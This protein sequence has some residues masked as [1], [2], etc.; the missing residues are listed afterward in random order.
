MA[1]TEVTRES[2]FSRLGNSIKGM[3]GGIIL[4]VAGIGVTAWNEGRAV[5]T[6][7]GL[8]EGSAAVISVES[9][10][11][12]SA[13]E[14]RLVHLSGL[15]TTEEILRDDIFAVEAKALRLKRNA[16]ML[17]WKEKSSSKTQNKVG[18]GTETVTTYTYEKVWSDKVIPSD[19]FREAATHVNPGVLPVESATKAAKVVTLGGFQLGGSM[20]G[21]VGKAEPLA[22]PAQVP[23]EFKVQGNT[24]YRSITPNAVMPQPGAVVPNPLGSAPGAVPAPTAV[25]TTPAAMTPQIGD[26][27]ITFEV[28]KPAEVSV[29]AQQRGARLEPY[30]TKTGTSIELVDDGVVPAADMFAAAVAANT[31]MTWLLRLGGFVAMYIGMSMLLAPLG[32]LADVLPI[33][34]SIM[35]FGTSLI[36]VV[37]AVPTSLVT[38]AIAWLA[39]RPV[40][41]ITLL[42]IGVGVPIALLIMKKGKAA[43]PPPAAALLLLAGLLFSGS[44]FQIHASTPVGG[45]AVGVSSDGKFL[46]AAGDNRV[47]YILDPVTLETK[48]RILADTT[49]VKLIFSKDN[50]RLALLD[51]SDEIRLFKTSDWS[52]DG[53]PADAPYFTAAPMA[54]V[55][56]CALSSPKRVEIRSLTDHKVKATIP[57]PDK[58]N[59]A[60][61][62]LDS[63]GSRVAVLFA[64]EDDKSETKQTP[65][66]DLKRA[67]KN[68]FVHANDAKSSQFL[69]ADATSGKIIQQGKTG[70][71]A[72]YSGAFGFID[73][74]DFFVV[75]SGDDNARIKSDG[76]FSIFDLT[77][78]GFYGAGLSNDRKVLAT[79]S[80]RD[81]MLTTVANI[82]PVKFKVDTIPGWPEYFQSFSFNGDGTLYGSTSAYRV[83][84]IA[85]DG[86]VEKTAS[87]Y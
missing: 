7:K 12:D 63:K 42:V 46:A 69:I 13:N 4:F 17:Q 50:S 64:S 19:G 39:Y 15:A 5:K 82:Q 3:I 16:E 59:A 33:L 37:V 35:R 32:V 34:G 47:L 75:K 26:V 85:K 27:R 68:A 29:V 41:G 73:E 20:P 1:T 48:Q 57:L 10:S 44:G 84:R 2:W 70:Y 76:S 79:G 8:E 38:I 71:S 60:L 87:V 67:E 30:R 49:V 22:P 23:P 81:G 24:I 65:P 72:P 80:M 51:T 6:A 78:S 9:A 58:P 43:A 45:L 25:A 36:A 77:V 40:L 83:T 56:A 18:G 86:K 14:G 66:T 55:Y 11:A 74:G 52:A 28:V 54:D 21:R 61:L 31:M 53:T 62:G